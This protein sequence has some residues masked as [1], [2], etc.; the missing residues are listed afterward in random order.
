LEEYSTKLQ[1]QS[2]ELSTLNQ[3][4]EQKVQERTRQL[5]V[6]NRQLREEKVTLQI[7]SI[8]DGLTGLYNRTYALERFD[9]EV[10]A[11]RR[12]RKKLSV[13]MFDLDHF[14]RVND[15]FGHQIGDSVLQRVAQ[16]FRYTLRDSDLI[17]R[18]GG[19]EFLIVLPETDCME[20][21]FVA[22][23]IRRDVETQKWSET[24]L[25]VTISGGV[26]EYGGGNAEQ[27]IR[28]ADSLMYQAKQLGRNRIVSETSMNRRS[29][30]DAG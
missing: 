4:L 19:E 21:T 1:A 17:G 12:Y 22:E 13:I 15:F 10:S 27:L 3:S 7:T 30:A 5:E 9:Q 26:A 16:I 23:R 18:Y 11:A 20:A 8:T 25:E 2:E 6:A 24:R 14:K 29:A 28:R